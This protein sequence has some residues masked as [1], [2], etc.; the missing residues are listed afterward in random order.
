[1]NAVRLV[2]ASDQLP[3]KISKPCT[4]I[5]NTDPSF[6]PGQHWNAFFIDENGYGEYFDSSG[7]PPK[8]NHYKVSARITKQKLDR[9]VNLLIIQN[10]YD[11][12]GKEVKNHWCWI[13]NLS[14]LISKQVSAKKYKVW[15]CERCLHYFYSEEK[16]KNHEI[17]CS[18]I[19]ECRVQMPYKEE[20]KSVKF[21]NYNNSL[22]VLFIIYADF[23]SQLKPTRKRKGKNSELYQEHEAFS[24]G[25]Y[26]HCSYDDSLSFY[27]THRGPDCRKWFVR[28]LK[29]IAEDMSYEA[30]QDHLLRLLRDVEEEGED[31]IDEESDPEVDN[32][33]KNGKTD[34]KQERK[35]QE[36]NQR[37]DNINQDIELSDE[38]M[39]LIMK[40]VK[41]N[42]SAGLEGIRPELIKYGS[43]KFPN[44]PSMESHS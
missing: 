26:F 20:D 42:K 14:R 19:N 35:F 23:E 41:N 5:A 21:K 1:M 2:C 7:R 28:E 30:K 31:P 17:D 16:L 4:V 36:H 10:T 18:E 34:T 43:K 24:V 13:E 44:K 6:R 27:K 25:Y 29:Q 32:V 33:G 11:N 3:T 38:M 40:S 12:D 37:Q 15:T 39:G 9:H 8:G 22:G